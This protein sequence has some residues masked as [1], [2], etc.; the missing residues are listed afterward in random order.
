MKIVVT[1]QGMGLNNPADPRFG[2]ANRLH[3]VWRLLVAVSVSLAFG[4]LV[5]AADRAQGSPKARPAARSDKSKERAE[6]LQKILSQLGLGKGAAVADIGAGDGQDTWV[7][8]SLVGEKGTV[9]AEEIGKGAVESLKK[10]AEKRAFSQVRTVPGRSDD[11]CLPAASADM[12]Y[13]HYVFHHFVKPREMLRGIWRSL[14]PGGYL[15]VVDKERGTLREWVAEAVREGKHHWTAETTVVREAREEGFAFVQCAEDCWYGKDEFV[16]VFQR[17][18]GVMEPGRDPDPFLPLSVDQGRRLLPIGQ[19]YQRPVFIALG[20]SRNLI[21]SILKASSGPGLDIV[22]E[23][24]ATQREERPAPPP[25]VSMPSVLTDKGDPHL[26]VE[27]VDAVFFLD[28]YHLLFR[29][30]ILLAK[31]RE[32]LAANGF[33]Y[34]LDREARQSLPHREASHSRRIARETVIQEMIKAGFSLWFSG[35]QPAADRFLIVFGKA[36]L[37][38]IS[39]KDDPFVG[40]PEISGPPGDWLKQNLWRLRGMKTKD[41]KLVALGASDRAGVIETIR[42]D[43]PGKEAWQLPKSKLVLSFDKRGDRYLLSDF[44]STDQQH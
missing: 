9:F 29:S 17:P 21:P 14:K 36:P 41:G 2:R 30:E 26:G 24:W 44:R 43:A 1:S 18:Q 12:A 8:A 25:H 37:A 20:Q 5:R 28:S 35:P 32:K 40:G 4:T 27:P 22:L 23:E 11:P 39:S 19:P 13:L 15:V 16:L 38:S 7:F 34:V 42:T 3:I 31:L 6:S 33:V 10:E